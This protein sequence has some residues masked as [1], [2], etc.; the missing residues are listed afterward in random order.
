MKIRAMLSNGIVESRS[1]VKRPLRYIFPVR[2]ESNTS[3]PVSIVEG[4]SKVHNDVQK[5]HKVDQAIDYIE[6]WKL[7]VFRVK[8]DFKWNL[9]RIIDR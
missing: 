3:S 4:G 7:H 6:C 1:T 9:K 8:S 5:K 2:F